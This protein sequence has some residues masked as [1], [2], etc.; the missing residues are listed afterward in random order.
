M[1]ISS[2]LLISDLVAQNYKTATVFKKYKI[3]FCCNG[4]KSILEACSKRNVKVDDV[5]SELEQAVLEIDQ[6]INFNVWE[7]DLLADYIEKTHHRYVK[8]KINEIT[9]FLK[10]VVKVH[11]VHNPELIE[12]EALFLQSAEDLL[13]HL[14]KEEMVLFPHIRTMVEANL[15]NHPLAR[16]HFGTISN[17]ISMMK[18]EHQNEGDRFEKISNLTNNYTP[19]EHA[20]NT[21]KVTFALLKDFEDDLH[22]HVHLENNILFPKAVI[23]E[24]K[25]LNRE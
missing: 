9:P 5:L 10:K 3:D 12:I 18:S 17:P 24:Q 21:Y 23:L 22:K 15:Y 8:S 19:P 14:Q 1:N 6:N 2:N 16:P 20:C 11:S 25:L 13:A 4:N 7:L